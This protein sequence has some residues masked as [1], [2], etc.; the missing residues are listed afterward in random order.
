MYAN[1]KSLQNVRHVSAKPVFHKPRVATQE[2]GR[3]EVTTGSRCLWKMATSDTVM[4]FVKEIKGFE[5]VTGSRWGYCWVALGYRVALGRGAEIFRLHPPL[6]P[7]VVSYSRPPHLDITL[8]RRLLSILFTGSPWKK[9]ENHWSIEY[10][11]N[12]HVH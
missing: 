5:W 6:T 2:P 8:G 11:P 7:P 1:K 3:H 9:F 4:K 10:G 12:H